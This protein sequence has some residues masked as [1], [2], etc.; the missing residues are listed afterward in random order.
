MLNGNLGRKISVTLAYFSFLKIKHMQ[1]QQ[2]EQKE[3][4][5][6]LLV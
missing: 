5:I 1:Q 3:I 4:F 2:E 6:S